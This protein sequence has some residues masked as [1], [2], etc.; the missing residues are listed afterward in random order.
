MQEQSQYAGYSFG[1]EETFEWSSRHRLIAIKNSFSN[2]KEECMAEAHV[3]ENHSIR[4][5]L[6]TSA[7]VLEALE[8]SFE[9][10]FE[11]DGVIYNSKSDEPWD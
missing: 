2:L 11:D 1:S 3:T 9:K 8:R 7:R 6:E 5:V 10:D 4:E